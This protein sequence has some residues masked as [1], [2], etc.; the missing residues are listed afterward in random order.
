[1]S[2]WIAI[3]RV[4]KDPQAF[5]PLAKRLLNDPTFERSEFADGFLENIMHWKRD[6]LTTRQGE[7]LLELRD[8]AEIHVVYKGLSIPILIRNCFDIRFELDE[9]A[10]IQIEKLVESRRG[11]VT[12]RQM[13]WFKRICKQLGEMENYM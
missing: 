7:I 1:M 6:E 3:D 8:E 2:S 11:Y 12:G 4:R 10:R 13:G 9:S 5:K